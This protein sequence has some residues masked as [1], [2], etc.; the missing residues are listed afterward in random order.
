LATLYLDTSALGRLLLG[1]K[2]APAIRAELP[3]FDQHVS[4]RLLALELRRLALRQGLL[5][6][7]GLLLSG[8]AMLPLDEALLTAAETVPP[9]TVATLDAIHLASALRLAADGRVDAIMTYDSRLAEGARHHGL[10][11][12]AP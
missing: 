4:S 7:A 3:R 10:E 11:V 2:D 12:V 9:P 5:E 8:V 6:N 1:E